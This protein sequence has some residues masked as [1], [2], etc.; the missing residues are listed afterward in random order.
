MCLYYVV[1]CLWVTAGSSLFSFVLQ[2]LQALWVIQSLYLINPHRKKSG[3]MKSG[4]WSGQRP[5]LTVQSPKNSC[6]CDD[7][8]VMTV[9]T[10]NCLFMIVVFLQCCRIYRHDRCS[11]LDRLPVV[12]ISCVQK[13]CY[14]LVNYCLIQ[15]FL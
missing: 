8:S 15:Y 14:Q 9:I 10:K 3:G 13:Y 7:Q 2:F 6:I 5:C 4:D 1:E 12:N 11:M